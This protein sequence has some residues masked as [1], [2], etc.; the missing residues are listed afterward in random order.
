L[1]VIQSTTE[2]SR[3][4]KEMPGSL[5]SRGLKFEQGLLVVTDG[6]R[7]LHKAVEGTFGH[8]ALLQR[9]PWHKREHVVCYL[10][11]GEQVAMRKALQ[12]ACSHSDYASGA[13]RLNSRIKFAEFY[14]CVFVGKLPVG[15]DLFVIAA[16]LPGSYMFFELFFVFKAGFTIPFQYG[17][18]YLCHVQPGAMGRGKDERYP[19]QVGFG[20]A[21]FIDLI[22]RAGT[23]GTEVI[24]HQGH[25]AT[26]L[27]LIIQQICYYFHPGL[28]R[29]IFFYTY[30]ALAC[31]R[32]KNHIQFCHSFSD[33][34]AVLEHGSVRLLLLLYLQQ[35]AG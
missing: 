31:Q 15:F 26:I 24:L 25:A 6:S 14:P 5:V 20:S 28:S 23:M 2:N 12:Q 34:F 16:L 19:V 9:C 18:F 27:V 21:G 3:C 22:E 17:E 7:G 33:I 1:D 30:I 35:L 32:L 11:E 10:K 4:I 8:Y 29:M 13:K